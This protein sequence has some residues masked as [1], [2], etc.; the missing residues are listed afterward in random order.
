MKKNAGFADAQTKTAGSASMPKGFLAIGLKMIYAADAE[1]RTKTMGIDPA[2]DI[3]IAI[4]DPIFNNPPDWV[5]GNGWVLNTPDA[6]WAFTGYPLG[7]LT[8]LLLDT[9][10][11]NLYTLTFTLKNAAFAH[12]F[13]GFTI[14]LS[15]GFVAGPIR[16]NGDYSFNIIADSPP[17]FLS[18]GP[19]IQVQ[20]LDTAEITDPVLTTNGAYLETVGLNWPDEKKTEFY[21]AAGADYWQI[22]ASRNGATHCRV[23]FNKP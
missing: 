13:A 11:G 7:S 21:K 16:A 8:Q 22:L 14:S 10:E 9:I 5:V 3:D 2:A 20:P 1:M 19:T 4:R 6:T 12:P 23:L 17:G 18:W 15:G